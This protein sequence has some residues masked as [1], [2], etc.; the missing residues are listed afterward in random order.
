MNKG[1]SIILGCALAQWLWS[2]EFFPEEL[3]IP[4]ATRLI[5]KEISRID[6]FESGEDDPI[7]KEFRVKVSGEEGILDFH[8]K[9]SITSESL[10]IEYNLFRALFQIY[11]ENPTESNVTEFEEALHKWRNRSFSGMLIKTVYIERLKENPDFDRS[12][13][14]DTRCLLR[15][16][17]F[18]VETQTKYYE[19]IKNAL[20][21][22]EKLSRLLESEVSELELRITKLEEKESKE[23]ILFYVEMLKYAK[24]QDLEKMIELDEK[25]TDYIIASNPIGNP[26][27]RI[28]WP[29]W[30]V[31]IERIQQVGR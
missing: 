12:R 31:L 1:I 6:P 2:S 27:L 30:A 4:E 19:E 21:D 18:V 8:P 17:P 29:R 5:E 3:S 16:L 11:V 13:D 7:I 28:G 22:S 14:L 10:F 20:G 26:A 25:V 9:A 23:N 24:D 15:D